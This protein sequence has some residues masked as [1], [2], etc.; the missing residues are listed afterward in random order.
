M[1]RITQKDLETQI[2]RLN[3]ICNTPLT[4]RDE[5]TNKTSIGHYCLDYAYSGVKLVQVSND[6]GGIREKSTGGFMTKKELF[7]QLVTLVN[8]NYD[9]KN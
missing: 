5:K 7:N 1:Q 9:L 4:Y 3:T 8:F 2:K 6:G